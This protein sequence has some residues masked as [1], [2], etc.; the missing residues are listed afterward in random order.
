MHMQSTHTQLPVGAAVRALTMHADDRGVFTEVFRREWPT[1]VDPIQWNIVR[2]EPG[3]LRGVHVHVRHADYL[4]IVDGRATVGLRDLRTASPTFGLTTMLDLD[5]SR[6]EALTIPPGVAHGFCF[7]VAAA[8]LYSVSH[9]WDTAD[10]LGCCWHDAGLEMTWPVD[11]PHVSPRDRDAHPLADL[12]RELEP[13][14]AAFA[15]QFDAPGASA[16]D[17]EPKTAPKTINA[18]TITP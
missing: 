18:S 13:H 9:Y 6:L 4:L 10:E 3:V 11:E 14:Q 17:A 5:A 1:G 15:R 16:L 12:M 8:H 2:S 7:P